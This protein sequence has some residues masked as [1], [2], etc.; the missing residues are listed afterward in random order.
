[1]A[2]FQQGWQHARLQ[3]EERI[4][5]SNTRSSIKK[6]GIPRHNCKHREVDETI[7]SDLAE[8]KK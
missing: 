2:S 6:T 4:A 7:M 8:I 5:R 1:M 3:K